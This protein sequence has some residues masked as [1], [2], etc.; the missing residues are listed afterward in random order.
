MGIY[1]QDNNFNSRHI[2]KQ[3]DNMGYKNKFKSFDKRLLHWFNETIKC[4]SLDKFMYGVTNIGGAVFTTSFLLALVAFGKSK[5]RV[6][7]LEALVS[8]SISQIFVQIFKKLLE[9]ERPYKIL[10]NI[11]TF[12]INLKDYSFPSGHTTASFSIATT[13]A[14]N[15]H[16][17]AIPI[18]IVAAIVG[19]SR[20]YL[21]VH[22]PTDVIAGIVLGTTTSLIIHFQLLQYIRQLSNMMRL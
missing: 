17:I 18:L 1:K 7:G 21:G 20:M 11:N 12:G 15:I 6:I 2:I 14:L 9:R 3:G 8:L 10:E 22:F 16:Q 5:L 4:K 13:L 19:I